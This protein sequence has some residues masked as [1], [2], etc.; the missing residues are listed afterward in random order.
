MRNFK[1]RLKTLELKN[2][3]PC[4][5][6]QEKAFRDILSYLDSLA[7]RKASGDAQVQAEI[8]AFKCFMGTEMD[9]LAVGN[10]VLYKEQQDKAL[11][12][13]YEERYELD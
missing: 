2:P 3:T 12:E 6:E 1:A 13:N 7:E 8:E 10:F 9:M 5:T 11:R 4:T